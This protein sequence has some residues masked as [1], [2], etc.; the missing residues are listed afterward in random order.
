MIFLDAASKVMTILAWP[1]KYFLEMGCHPGVDLY[2]RQDDIPFPIR[3]HNTMIYNHL[4]YGYPI[5]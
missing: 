3:L 5:Q 4:D 1:W 2:Q